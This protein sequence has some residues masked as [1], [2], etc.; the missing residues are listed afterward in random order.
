MDT[1]RAR[2]FVQLTPEAVLTGL[3]LLILEWQFFGPIRAA[4]A[5]VT[6]IRFSTTAEVLASMSVFAGIAKL[7]LAK[8]CKNPHAL[9]IAALFLGGISGLWLIELQQQV[10]QRLG[11]SP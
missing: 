3:G 8:R 7:T 9:L 1:P 4:N 5:H 2:R 6:G 11:Y 10:F